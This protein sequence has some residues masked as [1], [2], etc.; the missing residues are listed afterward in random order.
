ML[1]T[2]ERIKL[3]QEACHK[4]SERI[5]LANNLFREKKELIWQEHQDL[6]SRAWTEYNKREKE[7]NNS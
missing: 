3:L 5:D 1:N 7:I 6:V 2:D 4:R